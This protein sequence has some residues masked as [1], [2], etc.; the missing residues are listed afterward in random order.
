MSAFVKR[1][2]LL[3]SAEI[4]S[5]SWFIV[6]IIKGNFKNIFWKDAGVPGSAATYLYRI[7]FLKF[8]LLCTCLR[9]FMI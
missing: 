5:V 9:K 6:C 2:E 7:F 8:D 1:E 4:I 3:Y